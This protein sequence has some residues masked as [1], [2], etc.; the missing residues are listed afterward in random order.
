MRI[1]LI[2]LI[3]LLYPQ[4]MNSQ[5]ATA[6]IGNVTSCAG[7]NILVPLDVTGFT[8]VGAMTIYISYDTNAASFLSIQN[9]NPAIPGSISVNDLNGNI[10]IAYSF[11][12]PFT[13][14]SGNLFDLNFTFL[15]DSVLL[16]FLPGT[17]IANTNLEVIP[18]DTYPGSI[19]NSIQIINQPENVQSY[20]D[21]DVFF[22][23]TSLGT[24][25]YQWQENNGSGWADLQ[26][27]EI[28][29]GVNN[30]TLTIYDVPV[31]FNGYQYRCELTAG[32]CLEI[33]DT[34]SLEVASAFPVATLGFISSCPGN[35]IFEPLFVGDFLD[36]IEFTFN[37]SFDT[38]NLVYL[39]IVNIH[40]DLSPGDITVSPVIDPVGISIH[41]ENTNPLSI[42]SDKLF[43]LKFD[44]E[45]QDQVISFEQGSEVLNSF[46][47]PI[48]ITFN[49]GGLIQFPLPNILSQPVNDS[50]TELQDAHF[51]VVVSG[52]NNY[53]W[54][55]STDGGSSWNDLTDTPPYSDVN[56]SLLTIN[57][58]VYSMNNYQFSCRLE[59][60]FCYANSTSATLI[61]DTLTYINTNS[62]IPGVLV[63]PVPFRDF[64]TITLPQALLY[65]SINIFDAEGKQITSCGINET[66]LYINKVRLN[67]SDLTGGVYFLKL[68]G[69]LNG[70]IVT[71]LKKIIK[72]Y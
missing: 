31:S 19:A 25:E 14:S 61:V 45:N 26:N 41:W 3:I 46:A 4:I 53:Q 16:P 2:I 35:E 15:G 29:S 48:N 63:Y 21:N 62:D 39:D 28:Y 20:P 57:P 65:N 12:V 47:N 11:I 27:N 38:S 58:A 40:P 68:E 1:K 13:I 44:Y 42:I 34:A 37:I 50:V 36:V 64:V 18:L 66:Q 8:D 23:I 33:S 49:N 72:T 6:T 56:T 54:M 71:E 7:E 60:E 30:D 24:P 9:I 10:N 32:E 70:K 59:N 5:N 17:E 51:E 55:L 69:Q 67:L 43:D 52:A 22:R